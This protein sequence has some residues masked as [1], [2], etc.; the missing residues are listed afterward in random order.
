MS[1]KLFDSHC[2]LNLPELAQEQALHWQQAQQVGVAALL[3]PAVERPAWADLLQLHTENPEWPVALGIHPWWAHSHRL[4]D[5]DELSVLLQQQRD[6]VC[7]IG[8]IGLDFAL[9]EDTFAIQQQLFE[10]QLALAAELGKPVVLHHRKSQPH[11]LAAIKRTGFRE[12][13]ILHAFSGS[14]EQG[15]AFIEQG[16]KLGIGGTISYERA[17]KTRRAVQ[18]LPLT[19]FVLETDAPSMPLAGFQ[20]LVNTPAR[21]AQVFQHFSA[22]R[23]EPEEQLA[24]QL[25]FNTCQALRLG[26]TYP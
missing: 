14:P 12:G 18:Q 2:H 7:A 16:F 23:T 24:E 22:L 10:A 20:G 8:E 26:F 21:L 9:S 11:L 13:G 15:Q 3:I 1:L 6:N 5:V 17:N 19:A 25:W 4:S